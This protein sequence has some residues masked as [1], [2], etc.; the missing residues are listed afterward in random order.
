M[1]ST[2]IKHQ[3]STSYSGDLLDQVHGIIDSKIQYQ[4]F[5][6]N[7]AVKSYVDIE[8]KF[9][10]AT[11][12]NEKNPYGKILENNARVLETIDNAGRIIKLLYILRKRLIH[13]NAKWIFSLISEKA[14]ENY[15]PQAL[16]LILDKPWEQKEIA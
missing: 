3:A 6:I 11:P 15:T 10:S 4:E 14:F 7:Q 9:I 2:I 13:E 8:P 16:K 5:R 12:P 1:R